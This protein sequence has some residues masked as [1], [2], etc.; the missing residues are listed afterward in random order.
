[1]GTKAL[2]RRKFAQTKVDR[3]ACVRACV[4]ANVRGGAGV[5]MG[6]R[7]GGV[8][9][10]P[11]RRRARQPGWA[12]RRR[13]RSRRRLRDGRVQ[14]CG[15][16]I[17]I[18]VDVGWATLADGMSNQATGGPSSK[19]GGLRGETRCPPRRSRR[20]RAGQCVWGGTCGALL[21][22]NR[23]DLGLPTAL[24]GQQ[25]AEGV[26]LEGRSTGRT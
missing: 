15:C 25:T 14:G 2:G 16:G 6:H 26:Q 1:M 10:R 13:A 11:G 4:R 21:R 8:L 23:Q 22:P 18:K 7:I 19:S 24:P 12:C 17:N 20:N 5:C 3:R 9:R